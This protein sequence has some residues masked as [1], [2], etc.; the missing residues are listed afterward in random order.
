MSKSQVD[1]VVDSNEASQKPE[2]VEILVLHKGVNDYKIE[3][4]EAGDIET[5]ECVFERKSPSDFAASIEDGRMREQ[6]EKM[7]ALDKNAY[8]LIDG[9][10]EDFNNLHSDMPPKSL[11]G[12][13]ASIEENN[14]IGVKYCSTIENVADMAVRLARKSIEDPS[15]HVKQV[16]NVK[17][18][19]FMENVFLGIEGVGV[20]T[21]EKLAGEF[22]TL[23][24]VLEA[25]ESDFEEVE[26]VGQARSEQIYSEVH[27][28]TSDDPD[29]DNGV[30]VVTI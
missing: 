13:D 1:I 14:G 18:P 8:I 3:P 19:S 4:M 10:M 29:D 16:G 23:S 7:A 6:L 22:S 30:T 24:E 11:R 9:N 17:E 2:L 28:D 27:S 26:G 25:N 12:M 15:H 21:A 20:E 5:E